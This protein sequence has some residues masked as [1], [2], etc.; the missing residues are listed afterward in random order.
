MATAGPEEA[1]PGVDSTAGDAVE[2]AGGDTAGDSEGWTGRSDPPAE[3][4]GG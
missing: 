3:A 1:G 2:A 4:E